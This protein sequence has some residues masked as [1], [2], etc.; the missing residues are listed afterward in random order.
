MALTNR[1]VKEARRGEKPCTKEVW[2]LMQAIEG[3]SG[4]AIT[5]LALRMTPHVFVR[6]GDF[7]Q[8]DRNFG[9]RLPL[10]FIVVAIFG[11][12]AFGIPATVERLVQSAT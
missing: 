2:A 11:M 4:H 12:I 7:C 9:A 3:Y 1:I 10:F 8:A 5:L 6:P